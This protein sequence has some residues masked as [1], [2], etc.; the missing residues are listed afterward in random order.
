[1][2]DLSVVRMYS[3]ARGDIKNADVL[4]YK[5]KGIISMLIRLITR[6]PY[7]H[8]GL[9]VQWYDRLMVMEAVGKGVI[10]TPLSKNVAHYEGGVEWYQYKEEITASDRQKMVSFAQQQLGKK[11]ARWK[12]VVAAFYRIFHWDIDTRDKLYRTK[13]LFCS[14]YISQVYN[15]IG[16]DLKEHKSDRFMSPSDIANS[17]YL[18]KMAILKNELGKEPLFASLTPPFGDYISIPKMKATESQ[19]E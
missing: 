12:M 6:S 14:Y 10:V 3:E 4:L 8:A 13:R 18:K 5:G 15:S 16:K 9:A 19:N 7:S 1:M 11:F 2:D 17:P